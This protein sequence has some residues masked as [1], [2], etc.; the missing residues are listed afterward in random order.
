MSED[1]LSSREEGGDTK[2]DKA[3][4]ELNKLEKTGKKRKE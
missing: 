2:K 1:T 4:G 3:F